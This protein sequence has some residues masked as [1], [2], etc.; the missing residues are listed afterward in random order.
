M[1]DDARPPGRNEKALP[2]TERLW[3]G[4]ADRAPIRRARSARPDKGPI[5][6]A[7]SCFA[8]PKACFR[9]PV[10][11]YGG[12]GKRAGKLLS[13]EIRICLALL[14]LALKGRPLQSLRLNF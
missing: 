9:A 7:P 14:H 5:L 12:E 8:G 11:R 6:A 10:R 13:V 3:A 2:K 1:K 4:L